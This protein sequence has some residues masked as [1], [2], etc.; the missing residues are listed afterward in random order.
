[1]ELKQIE[2]LKILTQGAVNENQVHENIKS[3]INT[4]QH[5]CVGLGK[6]MPLPDDLDVTK[7]V[8]LQRQL[9]DRV[10]E[11]WKKNS[12]DVDMDVY[13]VHKVC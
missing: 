13:R 7:A 11:I 6:R 9:L 5:K 2:N 10:I 1:M 3:E 8:K 4:Y 12:Q